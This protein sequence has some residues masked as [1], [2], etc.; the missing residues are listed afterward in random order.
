MFFGTTTVKQR[1]DE[2]KMNSFNHIQESGR[3]FRVLGVGKLYKFTSRVFNPIEEIFRLEYEMR[4]VSSVFWL[5][6]I[7]PRIDL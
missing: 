1:T 5:V 6:I 4:Q 3:T 7:H 2:T